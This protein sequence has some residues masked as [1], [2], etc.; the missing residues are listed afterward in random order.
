MDIFDALNIN[1]DTFYIPKIEDV[2]YYVKYYVNITYD[3]IYPF[4]IQY[5]LLLKWNP[6]IST[7]IVFFWFHMVYYSYINIRGYRFTS[8]RY[9]ISFILMPFSIIYYM[10]LFIDSL[11]KKF[12]LYKIFKLEY[13]YIPYKIR[14]DMKEL[15]GIFKLKNTYIE[16]FSVKKEKKV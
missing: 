2:L 6:L 10:I 16:R 5:I 7:I 9:L 4:L 14:K 15:E 13:P 12:V 11:F 8:I 3:Y 1:V